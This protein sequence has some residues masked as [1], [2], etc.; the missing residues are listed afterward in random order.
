MRSPLGLPIVWWDL[1][2]GAVGCIWRLIGDGGALGG[3]LLV[4]SLADLLS[5]T[6]AIFAIAVIGMLSA[7]ILGFFVPET[8]QRPAPAPS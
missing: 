3:P 5:L 7:S 6:P 8:L 4:G 1:S 2:W